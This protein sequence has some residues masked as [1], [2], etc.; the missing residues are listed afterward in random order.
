MRLSSGANKANK[1]NASITVPFDL[2][3]QRVLATSS[4]FCGHW[5]KSFQH[6]SQPAVYS[7][8]HEFEQ[9]QDKT[10]YF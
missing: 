2:H 1:N 8:A 7:F 5:S 3:F 4:N 10:D 6:T 9:V